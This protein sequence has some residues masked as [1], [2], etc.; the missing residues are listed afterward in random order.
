VVSR[1]VLRLRRAWLAAIACVALIGAASA[2]AMRVELFDPGPTLSPTIY[3]HAL[4]AHALAMLGVLVG[5]FIAIPTLITRPGRSAIV[6]G[7]VAFVLWAVVMAFFVV[8]ACAPD[9]WLSSSPFTPGSL[10]AATL[11][12]AIAVGAAASQ[13]AASLVAAQNWQIAAAAIGAI[14][15]LVIVAIP[16]ATGELPTRLQL[17]IAST[18]AV[19]SIV[20]ASN[21]TVAASIVWTAA[22][23][24]LVAAW[25]AL[26]ILHGVH[27]SFVPDT[28]AMLAPFPAVGGAVLA[29]LFVAAARER[30]LRLPLARVAA[31]MF[32]VGAIATSAAFLRLGTQGMP[33]RY[34]QYDPLF[35]PLQIVVGV[36]AALT[37]L[38]AMVAVR[39][40]RASR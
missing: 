8:A 26:A 30:P 21:G 40:M 25:I 36:A 6:L 22:V 3:S 17:Q 24:C 13:L 1:G 29:A 10:R 32:A 28:V 5:A 31:A 4:A 18:L 2:L 14:S 19:A 16:L 38:G 27:V 23:P 20:P 37:L 9:D 34:Q 12:L 35:Q 7:S 33:R 15:A 11:V 39:S